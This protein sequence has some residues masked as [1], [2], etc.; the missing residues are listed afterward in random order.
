[1][2]RA[3]FGL[4]AI[5]G[6]FF[7]WGAATVQLHVWPYPLL[8]SF[9]NRPSPEQTSLSNSFR[10]SIF[11]AYNERVDVVFLGDSITA[12]GPWHEM[13]QNVR[14]ANR[15]IGGERFE[16]MLSR[17]D[18]V[19]L[20]NPKAVFIMGGVNSAGKEGVDEA[21][22][23]LREIINSLQEEGIQVILQSTLLP[24]GDRQ[25]FVVE[26]NSRLDDLVAETGVQ[27]VDLSPL[28]DDDG[29]RQ[30]LTLDGT[31]LVGAGYVEWQS[32]IEPIVLNYRTE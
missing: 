26:L 9:G 2:I 18:D 15:G 14:L 11:D 22:A 13:F 21:L 32:L 27:F 8:Q 3:F 24:R 12:Q 25:S 31:H 5:A 7:V 29:V 28:Q 16:N 4:A 20:L 1:M 17:L 30:E 10:R 23:D 19:I 6:L